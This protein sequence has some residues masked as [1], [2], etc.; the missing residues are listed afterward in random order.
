MVE[1]VGGQASSRQIH[2]DNRTLHDVL[3]DLGYDT[4]DAPQVYQRHVTKGGE[5]VFTGTAAMVWDWL[6]KTGQVPDNTTWRVKR[7]KQI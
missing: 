3:R 7:R 2:R 6:R 1:Q 5:I 4:K